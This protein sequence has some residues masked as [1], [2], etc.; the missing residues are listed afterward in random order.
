MT[1]RVRYEVLPTAKADREANPALLPWT[2]TRDGERLSTHQTKAE[3]VTM[4]TIT[5]RCAWQTSG[6]HGQVRIKGRRGKIQDERT[7]GAD[8]RASKG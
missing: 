6:Q 7:Y 4:A 1:R 2:V 3:A 5:A 8:P